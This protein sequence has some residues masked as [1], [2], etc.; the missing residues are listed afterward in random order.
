[1]NAA[2]SELNNNITL[3]K[4]SYMVTLNILKAALITIAYI[5]RFVEL[6]CAVVLITYLI[7]TFEKPLIINKDQ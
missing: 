2:M 7:N 6:C 5:T 1:M 4:I 3:N